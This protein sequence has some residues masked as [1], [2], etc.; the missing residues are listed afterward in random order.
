[1]AGSK[2]SF[3]GK[4]R[5]KRDNV[6]PVGYLAQRDETV[7]VPLLCQ[8]WVVR[9]YAAAHK[10]GYLLHFFANVSVSYYPDG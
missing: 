3:V 8:R 4:R 5:V 1:M 6:A 7:V 2:L 9:Q 10:F